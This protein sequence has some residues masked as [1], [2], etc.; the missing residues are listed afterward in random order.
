LDAIQ[1]CN[2]GNLNA[3]CFRDHLRLVAPGTDGPELYQLGKG[4]VAIYGLAAGWNIPVHVSYDYG[5]SRPSQ[6]CIDYPGWS[7]W[8]TCDR[9]LGYA[10]ILVVVFHSPT[11]TSL[12]H[13]GLADRKFDD[14]PHG[15]I[16]E[17]PIAKKREK[18]GTLIQK[19]LLACFCSLLWHDGLFRLADDREINDFNGH[20]ACGILDTYSHRSSDCATYFSGRNWFGIFPRNMGYN[21]RMLDLL[22]FTETTCFRNSGTRNGS[23]SFLEVLVGSRPYVGSTAGN[24]ENSIIGR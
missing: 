1:L 16:Y 2:I 19:C 18:L 21:T 23:S 6:G 20:P 12:D 17:Q 10:D 9:R 22:Y 4:L 5:G 24:K 14:R 13:P 7:G 15:E 3:D 8:W 11:S